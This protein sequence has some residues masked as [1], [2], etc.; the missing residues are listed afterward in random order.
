M[1]GT[2]ESAKQYG[3][4]A[5]NNVKEPGDDKYVV[6]CETSG[7]EMESWYYFIRYGNN[8]EALEYL[9]KQLEAVDMYVIDDLSAFDLDLEHF[10]SETTAK[11]MIRLEVNTIYHRKFDGEL[12]V[13]NFGFKK[14]D[15]NDKKI[16][17]INDLICG[18]NIDKYI[19]GEDTEGCSNYNSDESSSIGDG[20]SDEDDE[21]LFPLPE[22]EG[23]PKFV[24]EDTDEENND[25]EKKEESKGK[26]KGKSSVPDAVQVVAGQRRKKKN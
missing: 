17:R 9:Q 23:G 19:D 8:R 6:L 5:A 10:F 3:H 11:E 22:N 12:S 4:T 21:E 25:S 14:R 1:S 18:G 15:N 16:E 24:R 20:N 13:I 26:G 7:E 2:K